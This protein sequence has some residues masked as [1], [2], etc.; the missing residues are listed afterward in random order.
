MRAIISNNCREPDPLYAG[1]WL[2]G[3]GESE[4]GEFGWWCF[5]VLRRYNA[6]A[7]TIFAPRRSGSRLGPWQVWAITFGRR[8][9]GGLSVGDSAFH[10]LGGH[11]RYRGHDNL[12]DGIVLSEHEIERPEVGDFQR[13][14]P[15][16]CCVNSGR[17]QMNKESCSC[18]GAFSVDESNIFCA[19]VW[20]SDRFLGLP[21]QESAWFD[22]DLAAASK[23][24]LRVVF[25]WRP[26]ILLGKFLVVEFTYMQFV[27]MVT[28]D[29]DIRV[30]FFDVPDFG[31]IDRIQ[32]QVD[33][34]GIDF[35]WLRLND[36]IA[37]FDCRAQVSVR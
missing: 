15:G 32:M 23:Y 29:T 1:R 34:S 25:V 8:A 14:L 27:R 21:E 33:R 13:D 22:D 35:F 3:N 20:G 31:L 5:R 26:Q 9:D 16:P 10:S 6:H 4:A 30:V 28:G 11:A 37:A 18:P 7:V 19:L 36:Q 12:S 24:R 2:G 17:G